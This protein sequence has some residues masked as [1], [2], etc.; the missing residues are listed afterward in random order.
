M[1]DH[2]TQSHTMAT[3]AQLCLQETFPSDAGQVLLVHE[4]RA[5]LKSLRAALQQE[6][7]AVMEAGWEAEPFECFREPS[8]LSEATEIPDLIIVDLDALARAGALKLLA[9]FRAAKPGA[10]LILLASW[11]DP[12]LRRRVEQLPSAYLLDKP[13]TVDEVSY[14]ALS[15]LH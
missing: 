13:C 5:S 8:G 7:Y 11:P 14:L 1:N 12:E 10:R 9:D 3:A 2:L 4:P 6:G 15:L